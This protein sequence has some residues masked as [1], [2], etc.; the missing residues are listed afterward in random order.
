MIFSEN[1]L[2]HFT[3]L[4]T[5]FRVES[6]KWSGVKGAKGEGWYGETKGE[7]WWRPGRDRF[8]GLDSSSIGFYVQK[9]LLMPIFKTRRPVA[10]SQIGAQRSQRSGTKYA[11]KFKLSKVRK[12]WECKKKGWNEH[13]TA[14][15]CFLYNQSIRLGFAYVSIKVVRETIQIHARFFVPLLWDLC[16]PIWRWATGRLVLKIGMSK[17][18]WT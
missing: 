1:F 7:T 13:V 3:W 17:Y 5:N 18:F 6:V 10:H 4:H 16:A 12:C 14:P 15:T 2:R 11:L 9:Y 8:L